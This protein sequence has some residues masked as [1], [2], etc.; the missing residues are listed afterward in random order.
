MRYAVKTQAV[1][2]RGVMV[3]FLKWCK[4]LGLFRILCFCGEYALPYGMT[5]IL[6]YEKYQRK[7]FITYEGRLALIF[8][9]FCSVNRR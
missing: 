4:A 8:R 2:T 9:L 1:Y 7:L 3:F 5:E 6:C